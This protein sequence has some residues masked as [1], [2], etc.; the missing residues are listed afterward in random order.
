MRERDDRPCDCWNG[1]SGGQD[2][3][4]E[5]HGKGRRARGDSK[6][7]SGFSRYESESENAREKKEKMEQQDPFFHARDAKFH[8]NQVASL[9]SVDRVVQTSTNRSNGSKA[10]QT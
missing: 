2:S 4:F 1:E 9:I 5:K 10:E 6:G 3:R 7:I 8:T